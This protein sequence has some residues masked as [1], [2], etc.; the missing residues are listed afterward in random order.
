MKRTVGRN[1]RMEYCWVD[2]KNAFIELKKAFEQE[3][4]EYVCSTEW[5]LTKDK[6]FVGAKIWLFH[7]QP[8]SRDK[9]DRIIAE[10]GELISTEPCFSKYVNVSGALPY[11]FKKV[12]LL[13]YLIM[14]FLLTTTLIVNYFEIHWL[15][16]PMFFLSIISILLFSRNHSKRHPLG[17]W[18]IMFYESVFVTS[19]TRRVYTAENM[20][21]LIG[22]NYSFDSTSNWLL[23]II[24]SNWIRLFPGTLIIVMIIS[25]LCL[26]WK[27]LSRYRLNPL[28]EKRSYILAVLGGYFI[29][30]YTVI[31]SFGTVFDQYHS[32]I[33]VAC[34]NVIADSCIK[35]DANLEQDGEQKIVEVTGLD[36]RL[37]AYYQKTE[38]TDF[39]GIGPYKIEVD[40]NDGNSYMIEP[41]VK[42]LYDPNGLMNAETDKFMKY[43][44]STYLG[45]NY[46]E[47][48]PVAGIIKDLTLSE[49]LI[50]NIMGIIIISIIITIM[51]LFF[52]SNIKNI[53]FGIK[54]R[55]GIL[56]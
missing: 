7:F 17:I 8:S 49:H 29:I 6:R 43:S 32:D 54:E 9:V 16:T 53:I 12:Y 51:Q 46:G 4:V 45:V 21:N 50:S 39:Y 56:N 1:F 15:V 19:F 37:K 25:L 3:G 5:L 47:A 28:S 38:G 31:S 14:S 30:V 10:H 18:L 44:L 52:D 13:N 48:V 11:R 2:D 36:Y 41:A 42:N 23:S 34:V 27:G 26:A 33:Y 20:L 35:G 24:S 55:K 22:N 40:E